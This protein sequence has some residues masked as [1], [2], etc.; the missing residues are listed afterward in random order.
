MN[1]NKSAGQ[2]WSRVNDLMREVDLAIRRLPMHATAG[3]YV[4]M[5]PFRAPAVTVNTRELQYAM[6]KLKQQLAKLEADAFLA[7]RETGGEK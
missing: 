5:V 6:H 7:S 4:P 2:R 1:T 3:R